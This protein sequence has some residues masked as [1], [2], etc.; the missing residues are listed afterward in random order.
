MKAVWLTLIVIAFS[1][2]PGLAL[3]SSFITYAPPAGGIISWPSFYS[4]RGTWVVR[5]VTGS[6]SGFN[7]EKGVFRVRGEGA[8]LVKGDSVM[9]VTPK[10]DYGWDLT[11]KRTTEGPVRIQS[12][13]RVYGDDPD[14]YDLYLHQ[15]VATF[16]HLH[17]D[18]DTV[19]I[20]EFGTVQAIAVRDGKRF[21]CDGEFL[22]ALGE[23]ESEELP[24]YRRRAKVKSQREVHCSDCHLAE[25][26]EVFV[27]A[28]VGTKGRVTWARP[29]GEGLVHSY[30]PN[31][32]PTC[33]PVVWA[34]VERGLQKFRY[35]SALSF[36]RPVSDCV[37]LTVRVVP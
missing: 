6:N 32:Y 21:R 34:A 29:Y 4:R 36:D 14:S 20:Q 9:S 13:L 1:L 18:V 17:D 10:R 11:W 15:V 16:R 7:G 28:T 25:A 37:V 19:L 22:V 26:T 8:A 24:R 30:A 31:V 33:D 12:S 2:S 5:F 3:A 27:V 35:Q 23:G